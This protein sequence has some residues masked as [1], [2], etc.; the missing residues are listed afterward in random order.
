MVEGKLLEE[1]SEIEILEDQSF[2]GIRISTYEK[3]MNSYS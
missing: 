2:D 1:I 3:L